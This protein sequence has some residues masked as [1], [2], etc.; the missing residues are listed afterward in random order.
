VVRPAADAFLAAL[1]GAVSD[2]LLA[3]G[4]R[5]AIAAILDA[6]LPASGA[7]L[8]VGCGARPR[9]LRPG[10]IGIDR[11]AVVDAFARHASV[12][13]GDAAALPFGDR[14]FAATFSVGLLHHLPDEAALKAASEMLRVTAAGGSVVVFDGVRPAAGRPLATLIR[15]LDR[16]HHM[17]SAAV[18]AALLDGVA[19]WDKSTVVYAATGL[20][21]LVA[22]HVKR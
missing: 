16:G 17:R 10:L 6:R 21:A 4:A 15:A 22:V 11:G 1:R 12:V 18:L 7:I 13:R 20:E 8:D 3:P 5:A 19:A 2:A 9:L 14:A